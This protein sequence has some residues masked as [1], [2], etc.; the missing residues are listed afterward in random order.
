MGGSVTCVIMDDQ[1]C[2]FAAI[3]LP[4]FCRA[5]K[6]QLLIRF[7]MFVNFFRI[8]KSRQIFPAMIQAAE[9]CP[10]GNQLNWKYF[11]D[12]LFT[13]KNLKLVHVGCHFKGEHEGFECQ[14]KYFY[15]KSK[16]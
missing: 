2:I 4:Q 16:R 5:H 11:F 8:E 6:G 7:L 9:N 3:E 12:L 13:R 14:P 10:R 1:S 15:T